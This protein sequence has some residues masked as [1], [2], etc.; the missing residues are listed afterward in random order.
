MPAIQ[1]IVL[2]DGTTPVTLGPISHTAGQTLYRA[3]GAAIRAANP[4]LTFKY[5]EQNGVLRQNV[6]LTFPVTSVDGVTGDT[7]VL[8]NALYEFSTRVPG[9][10]SPAEQERAAQLFFSLLSGTGVTL[11]TELTTGEGQWG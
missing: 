6:R 2:T 8:N 10:M 5:K 7:T 4:S 11:L 3:S 1:P 9:E